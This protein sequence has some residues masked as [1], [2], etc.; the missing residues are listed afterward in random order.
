MIV[1]IFSKRKVEQP[2][3][4]AAPWGPPVVAAAT[5]QPRRT[6]ELP[7]CVQVV[8]EYY[9]RDHLNS[10]MMAEPSAAGVDGQRY[11]VAD[12]VAQLVPEPKN[13]YD[14]NAV[15]V[16]VAGGLCGYLSRAD[17]VEFGRIIAQHRDGD[18]LFRL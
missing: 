18:A 15:A 5:V 12:L 9:R 10:I 7:R 6:V 17:A 3:G 13:E 16:R 2:S 14:S 8:G 4:A 1:G 11:G